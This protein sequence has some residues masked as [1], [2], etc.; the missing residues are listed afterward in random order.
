MATETLGWKYVCLKHERLQEAG[1]RSGRFIWARRLNSGS[2][3]WSLRRSSF[4][5]AALISTFQNVWW[6]ML[7]QTVLPEVATPCT[8]QP[9]HTGPLTCWEHSLLRTKV[10]L[11]LPQHLPRSLHVCVLVL[12]SLFCEFSL[13]VFLH[14]L[15]LPKPTNKQQCL[16]E[17]KYLNI[18]EDSLL[19]SKNC[20]SLLH[21]VTLP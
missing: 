15:P 14:W 16:K 17:S 19:S 5:T 21:N 8:Q 13:P 1:G 10:H 20:L 9:L 18:P 3:M 7:S 2:Q 11:E 6:P 12:M 4:R